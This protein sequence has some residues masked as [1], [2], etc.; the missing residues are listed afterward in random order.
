MSELVLESGKRVR[1]VR[2]SH[3][4][5]TAARQRAFLGALGESC[6]V[7]LAARKAGVSTSQAYVRRAQ[8][9]GF[10]AGWDRALATGYAQLE[11]VMLERALHGVEKTVI[12]RDGSKT[13]MREYSDR[14][15]LA[16][17]R[18]HRENARFADESVDDVEW[19][20]ARDRIVGRL[21]RL[22]DQDGI[23]TK[24][25]ADPISLIG[26]ALARR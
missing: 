1:R 14:V 20:E 19:Q 9:A 17:L 13:V 10:R 22:R 15:G 18:M 3:R 7:K 6:N 8:D 11:M 25:A 26:W 23:E 16:L 24:A 5:W 2:P 21:Q 12:A 4:S